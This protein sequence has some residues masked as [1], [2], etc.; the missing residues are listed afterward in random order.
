MDNDLR[1]RILARWPV[2][3]KTFAKIVHQVW[4]CNEFYQAGFG[5]HQYQ[6]LVRLTI[7]SRDQ[8][9][10]P[11]LFGHIFKSLSSDFPYR[12]LPEFVDYLAN[13]IGDT[14]WMDENL[15]QQWRDVICMAMRRL[16]LCLEVSHAPSSHLKSLPPYIPQT[17]LKP[18]LNSLGRLPTEQQLVHRQC[19]MNGRLDLCSEAL[20]MWLFILQNCGIDLMEYGN[21]VKQCFYSQEADKDFEMLWVDWSYC[22]RNLP[23]I[24]RSFNIR[25][26]GFEYGSEAREWKLWWSEPTDE[27]VGD[28]WR[29]MEPEPLH[30]PGSWYENW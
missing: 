16:C 1:V 3:T 24:Y 14:V 28:F 5:D 2:N 22:R 8:A 29:K 4:P 15:A 11:E 19:G 9:P 17:L 21:H 25:L 13:V 30:I 6:L 26:V 18:C 27:L 7:D 20:Y 23:W 12:R 10:S